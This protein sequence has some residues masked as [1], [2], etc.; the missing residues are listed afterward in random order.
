MKIQSLE[1][2]NFKRFERA[3][4]DLD[5]PINILVGPNSSGKSSVLKALLALKQTASISNE[6]EVLSAQGEYVDLGTYKDYVYNHAI[7]RSVSLRIDFTSEALTR[8]PPLIKDGP[9]WIKFSFLCDKTT[10]QAKLSSIIIGGPDHNLL[11]LER[12][13]TRQGF[14]IGFGSEA[15]NDIISHYVLSKS[16]AKNGLELKG[17]GSVTVEA[18][19]RIEADIELKTRPMDVVSAFIAND[20][21]NTI[22][23]ELDRTLFYIGPIRRAP[24]RSYRRTGHLMS[25][26]S[27]GEHTASVLANL[28]TRSSKERSKE[29]KNQN[30]I[31]QLAKWIGKIFPERNIS[32]ANMEELIKLVIGRSDG[33]G[34]AISDVGFGM[35]QLLPILVQITVMD[36]GST[37]LVEQPELHLHP[38][39]QTQLALIIAEAT[40]TGKRFIIETHSEHL[41]RGLQLAV[42]QTTVG[43]TDDYMIK[44]ANLNFLYIPIFPDKPHRLC[45]NEWGEFAE[46]WPSGFFDEAYQSTLQLLLNKGSQ[47]QVLPMSELGDK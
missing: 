8:M 3:N 36:E 46:T 44:P 43:N 33:D 24:S 19:Y 15:I 47:P 26:G 22:L 37:L 45:L 35:S 34:E 6:N 38:R 20:I 29:K 32:V 25:V 11:T 13:K 28:I 9:L 30:K 2:S 39:A 16:S 18:K 10:L 21:V 7:D 40:Y 23:R 5:A 17:K 4:L 42:S 1:L 41:I 31:N 12:K 14:T 27:A